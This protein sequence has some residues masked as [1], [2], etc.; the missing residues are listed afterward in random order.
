MAAL[1]LLKKTELIDIEDIDQVKLIEKATNEGVY[2]ERDLLN[3]YKRYQF[4]IN[5]LV[6]S[7]EIY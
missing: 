7:L 2:E 1:N 6:N 5:Q 4:D 3:L